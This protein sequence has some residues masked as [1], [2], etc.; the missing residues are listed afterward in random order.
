MCFAHDPW[1]LAGAGP[2][3]GP[4]HSLLR[5]SSALDTRSLPSLRAGSARARRAE[6]C[7]IQ[8][9]GLPPRHLPPTHIPSVPESF[10]LPKDCSEAT[11]SLPRRRHYCCF[12][13]TRVALRSICLGHCGG[14]TGL[15]LTRRPEAAP[16]DTAPPEAAC[17]PLSGRARRRRQHD[18][19]SAVG[20]GRGW[21][22]RVVCDSRGNRR[23]SEADTSHSHGAAWGLAQPRPPAPRLPRGLGARGDRRVRSDPPFRSELPRGVPLTRPNLLPASHQCDLT[24]VCLNVGHV[25]L[26]VCQ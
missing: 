17:R 22:G 24:S 23:E 11:V 8:R 16:T 7:A 1:H 4:D 20:D 21:G 12:G 25:V 14:L 15:L 2:A 13:Q 9:P 26:P 10:W 5:G 18:T 3:P 19:G 6:D